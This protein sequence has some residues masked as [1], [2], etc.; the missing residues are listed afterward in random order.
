MKA[1]RNKRYWG[2]WGIFLCLFIIVSCG[3]IHE[4]QVVYQ[5]PPP[6]KVLQGRKVVFR[7]VDQR[8]SKDFLKPNAKKELKHF[9]TDVSFAVAKY[10]EAGFKLGPYTPADAIR[11]AFKRRLENDGLVL[12]SEAGEVVPELEIVLEDFSLDY[13]ERQWA[14]SISYEARL[15]KGGRVLATQTVSANAQRY[16][17]LRREGADKAVTDVFNETVN[18]LDLVKLFRDARLL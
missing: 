8:P 9:S 14:A 11:D 17:I 7:F 2:I 3:S 4:V 13:I 1:A 18:R 5:L 6:G 16:K 12:V 10:R 15:K